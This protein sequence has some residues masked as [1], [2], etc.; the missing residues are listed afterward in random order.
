LELLLIRHGLPVRVENE[1]G[2][3]A[4]PALS[5]EGRRQADRI[6]AWLSREPLDALYASPLRRAQ[7]TAAPLAAQ[8]GME[9][10]IEPG[11]I[12]FDADSERYVPLEELREQDYERWKE[13]MKGGLYADHDLPSYQENVTATLEGLIGAHPGGRIA[14]F[15]HGGVIN[16]WASRV[17]GSREP[18]FFQP[19]YTS[20]H[21]FLASQGGDR[22]VLSLNEMAH[23]R[24]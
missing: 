22:S 20:L 18:L 16:V 23:L 10:G 11:V 7:E 3:P 19:G 9:V 13:L 21:R 1:D 6:A 2:A 15:C 14:V 24:E 12:E 8:L 4:D 17:I 5:F